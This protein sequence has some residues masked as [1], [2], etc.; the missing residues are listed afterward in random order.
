MFLGP[1]LART[2]NE[3]NNL[4]YLFQKLINFKY[5]FLLLKSFN[6]IAIFKY[7]FSFNYQMTSLWVW[8]IALVRDRA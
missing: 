8:P 4:T 3:T 6:Y 5:L 1:Y 2:L 7:F